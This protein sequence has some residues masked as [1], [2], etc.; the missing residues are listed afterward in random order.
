M[1]L[2]AIAIELD[3][4]DPS[5]AV[6]GLADR[7]GELRRHEAGEERLRADRRW[8]LAL[9][10]HGS[11]QAHW[12]RKLHI[13]IPPLVPLDKCFEIKRDVAKLQITAPA[14][15]VGNIARDVLGPFFRG[16][17]TD[18]PDR[19][20]VLPF[21]HVHDDRFEVGLLDVGF[22]V[23]LTASAEVVHDDVNA[24]IIAI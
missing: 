5:I 21:E 22:A 19:I 9:K 4:V 2:D 3:F 18:H 23:G 1:D 12:Q 14:Q 15:L 10:R 20:L 13:V 6:R 7:G 8:L 17:E 16:V 24:R 11:H